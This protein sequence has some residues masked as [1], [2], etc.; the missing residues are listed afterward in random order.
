[1]SDKRERDHRRERQPG[2]DDQ[3]EYFFP[4]TPPAPA[5]HSEPIAATVTRFNAERGFGFVALADGSGDAFLHASIVTGDTKD[6]C[7]GTRLHVRV[8]TAP[9]GLA[10]TEIVS[11]DHLPAT[12]TGTVKFYRAE[13]AFGFV[14]PDEKGPEIFVPAVALARSNVATLEP[15]QRV[16]LRVFQAKKGVEAHSLK[17]IEPE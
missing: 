6:I 5:A 3:P 16:E 15:G 8:A 14:T 12:V 1:M 4:A 13:K 9:R 2:F 7:P 10:V 11:I 17:L